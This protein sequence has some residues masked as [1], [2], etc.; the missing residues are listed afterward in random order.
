MHQIH[1]HTQTETKRTHLV[2]K[3]LTFNVNSK[4]STRFNYAKPSHVSD[5]HQT[6]TPLDDS[7][8]TDCLRCKSAAFEL[9]LIVDCLRTKF[10][11]VENLLDKDCFRNK[12]ACVED[13]L[14][15]DCL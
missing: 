13:L 14:K 9:L 6:F 12:S 5:G 1:T 3:Q 2:G 7:L 10:D 8:A 11:C 15:T 4:I